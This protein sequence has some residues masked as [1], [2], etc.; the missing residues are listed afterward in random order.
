MT[1]APSG[2]DCGDARSVAKSASASSIRPVGAQEAM[3]STSATVKP[4]HSV[5]GA[6]RRRQPVGWSCGVESDINFN[7][8]P[9]TSSGESFEFQMA[10]INRTLVDCGLR[11]RQLRPKPRTSASWSA[12]SGGLT[13]R[14]CLRFRS[15]PEL[16]IARAGLA[17]LD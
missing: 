3:A 12:S 11:H 1:P 7:L 16:G 8:T 4:R 2:L 5:P 15:F 9:L 14:L 6:P 10:C 17:A 13:G